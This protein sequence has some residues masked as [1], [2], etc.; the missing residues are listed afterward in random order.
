RVT[1]AEACEVTA[2]AYARRPRFVGVF[3]DEDPDVI[4]CLVDALRL[5]LAQLSG[6][7]APEEC[8]RLRVPYLKV[9]HVRSGMAA[10]DVLHI[11]ERYRDAMAIVLDSG[12]RRQ[13]AGDR[14]DAPPTA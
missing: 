13:A 4:G 6:D 12:G 5:D 8:T 3:V 10:Q 2:A 1:P 7:E 11:A 9:V 14:T